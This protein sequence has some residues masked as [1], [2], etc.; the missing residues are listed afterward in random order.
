VPFCTPSP[1]ELRSIVPV[2]A[3]VVAVC[4]STTLVMAPETP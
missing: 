2:P 3:N 4:V 1:S